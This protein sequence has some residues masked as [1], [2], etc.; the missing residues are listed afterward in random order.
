MKHFSYNFPQGLLKPEITVKHKWLSKELQPDIEKFVKIGRRDPILFDWVL[1]VMEN[2]GLSTVEPKYREKL[3]VVKTIFSL[4]EVLL[5]DLADN[6][7]TQDFR[8]FDEVIKSPLEPERIDESGLS[9]EELNYLRITKEIWNKSIIGEI[10]KF[11]KYEKYKQAF[12][13]DLLQFVNSMKYSRFVNA[14]K[15]ASNI[16][17]TEAYVH[18]SMYVL[19]QMDLDLMCSKGFEDSEFGML[20][21]VGYITQRMAKIDD[22][23]GTYQRELSESDMSSEAIVRLVKEYG[24]DFRFK[25]NGILN[26]DNR[27]PKFEKMLIEEWQK[28]YQIAKTITMNIKSVN[29]DEF[30]KERE[31]IQQAYQQKIRFW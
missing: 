16:V 25:L 10:K 6:E 31:F 26:K 20:R 3:A 2:L 23:L 24:T 29:M 21:E 1:R 12:D 4:W 27:Y 14:I 9:L 30:M 28:Q 15:E 5:D 13:F 7:E 8:L 19:I 18:H 22:L 11:P 17:E